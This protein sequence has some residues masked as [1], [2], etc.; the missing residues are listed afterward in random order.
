M[1][2][3]R[4]RRDANQRLVAPE[5]EAD[6]GQEADQQHDGITAGAAG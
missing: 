1:A 4:E 3:M 6:P 5:G 2:D